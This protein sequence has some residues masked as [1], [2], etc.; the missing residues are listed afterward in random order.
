[1]TND[2]GAN[3]SRLTA[4]PARMTDEALAALG[5]PKMVYIR[6]VA[7]KD[8]MPDLEGMQ[9]EDGEVVSLD[10]PEEAVLYAVHAADGERL[11]LVGDRDSAFI[12]ARQ[13]EMEPVSVH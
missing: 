4:A 1:M 6:E 7:A 12:A 3:N 2:N 10:L 11:A 8:V 9:N 5:G 13:H